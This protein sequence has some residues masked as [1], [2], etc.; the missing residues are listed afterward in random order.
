MSRSDETRPTFRVA[1]TADFY[2]ATGAPKYP[3][4]GLSVFEGHPHIQCV[5]FAEHRPQIGADQINNAQGVIVLTP[6]VTAQSVARANDLLAI[7]RF[8]VGYDAVDVRACTEANMKS[9]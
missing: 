3:D 5:P 7:G 9:S 2:D 6:S 8:G 1:M 4:L